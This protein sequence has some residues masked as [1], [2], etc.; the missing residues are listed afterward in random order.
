VISRGGKGSS[1]SGILIQLGSLLARTVLQTQD[2]RVSQEKKPCIR[3]NTRELN[4][5]LCTELS[6]LY[7]KP[8]G[9]CYTTSSL[10]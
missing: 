5:E 3:V 4:R 10:S 6:T 2:F 8:H 1:V 7:T 9:P